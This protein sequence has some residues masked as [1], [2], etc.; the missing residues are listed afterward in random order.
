[1]FGEGN[2]HFDEFVTSTD[3]LLGTVV[4][5]DPDDTCIA[6]SSDIAAFQW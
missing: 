4:F 2:A 3:V 1:M 6:F 5:I